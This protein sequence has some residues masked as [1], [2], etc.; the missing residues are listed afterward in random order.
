VAQHQARY[1]LQTHQAVLRPGALLSTGPMEERALPFVSLVTDAKCYMHMLHSKSAL[2][3]HPVS[4]HSLHTSDLCFISGCRPHHP[5]LRF[6]CTSEQFDYS[7]LNCQY[8]N[9]CLRSRGSISAR[10]L[11]SIVT[12]GCLRYFKASVP[13]LKTA[14]P[15]NDEPYEHSTYI[16][17]LANDIA[18][19]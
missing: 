8:H 4:N 3:A 9:H 15:R 17:R 5:L 1:V 10:P 16:T 2:S 6:L 18:I 12:D 14:H 11:I 13:H 7:Y 19:S